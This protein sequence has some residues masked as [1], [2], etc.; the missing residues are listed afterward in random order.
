MA[1]KKQISRGGVA[2]R[3]GL[4]TLVTHQSFEGQ[5][6]RWG[7]AFSSNQVL[8]GLTAYDTNDASTPH[9]DALV[10]NPPASVNS[11][12]TYRTNGSNYTTVNAPVT[13]AGYWLFNGQKTGGKSSFSG[14]YQKLNLI[15]G[16]TYRIELTLNPNDVTGTF[17]MNTYTPVGSTYILNS[18]FNTSATRSNTTEQIETTTFVASSVNNIFL[19]YYT[20]ESA[21]QEFGAFSDITIKEQKDFIMPMYAQDMFGNA[22][23]ILRKDVIKQLEE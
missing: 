13:T 21:S 22:H 15:K 20:T 4:E 14:M 6:I 10:N 9:I 11:W 16:N 19:I 23:K 1:T 17:F 18:T 7:N 8:S 12:L 2:N 5:F 3:S